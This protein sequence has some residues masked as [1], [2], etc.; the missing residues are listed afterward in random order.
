[1]LRINIDHVY[2]LNKPTF[3]F[4]KI[5]TMDSSYGVRSKNL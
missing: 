2:F 1:M 5:L 3:Y 4:V